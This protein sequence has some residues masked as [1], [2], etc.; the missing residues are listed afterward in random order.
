M[1]LRPLLLLLLLF[2]AG[3]VQVGADTAGFAITPINRSS[4]RDTFLSFL[5]ATDEIERLYGDYVADKTVDKVRLMRRELAQARRLMD[6]DDLPDSTRVKTGNAAIGY[7]RDILARLPPIDPAEI[8]GPPLA[9]HDMGPSGEAA[10]PLTWTIPGTEIQIAYI[11][12]G[13]HGG[14]YLF[15]AES[16][17]TL[18][19]Q[20][21]DLIQA[22]P[23]GSGTYPNYHED[24]INATGPLI[25]EEFVAAIPAA[26]K[27]SRFGTPAWKILA[28]A[29]IMGVFAIVALCWTLLTHHR[30]RELPG[31]RRILWHAAAPVGILALLQVSDWFIASQINPTGS[32]AAGEL[33][34]STLVRYA[35]GAWLVW[36]LIHLLAEAIARSPRA[37]AGADT[38]LLRLMARIVGLLAAGTVLVLGA[39]A[40]GIPAMGLIAGLGF[41]GIAVALASQ[42]TL[43]NLLAGVTL[44][45]DRPFRIGDH[46]LFDGQ[47]ASVERIG[48]RSSRLRAQDGTLYTVPNAD[49]AR[50][51]IVNYTMRE[52]WLLDQTIAIRDSTP[53]ELVRELLRRIR[54]ELD[55]NPRIER[56]EGW[57][58]VFVTGMIPGRIELRIQARVPGTDAPAFLAEQERILLFVL[59]VTRELA[60]ELAAPVPLAEPA[61]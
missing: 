32:F 20:Y 11:D 28:N 42:S 24:Q 61:A 50:S 53:P 45:A 48:P 36:L 10:P 59:S 12:D 30:A 38:H 9:G 55:E 29:L 6:L 52:S 1:Q 41:G 33:M 13:L 14:N 60:I 22:T 37:S 44:F 18:P 2:L 15:T 25:S 27:Q 19:R 47:A 35:S 7:L 5:A 31:P 21:E 23:P 34:F 51:H 8:P 57:P 56:A 58:R 17:A 16:L 54:A 40:I 46:I 43:E 4:P 3:P 26:L 49:L 39:D